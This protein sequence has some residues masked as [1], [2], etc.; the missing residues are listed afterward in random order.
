MAL[1]RGPHQMTDPEVKAWSSQPDADISEGLSE[2]RMVGLQPSPVSPSA[3]ACFLYPAPPPLCRC[4][5]QGLS[6]VNSVYT[7]QGNYPVSA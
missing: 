2:Q 1:P 3:Q 4:W 7:H 5:S 6:L